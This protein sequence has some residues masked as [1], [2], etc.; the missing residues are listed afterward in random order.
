[1]GRVPGGPRIHHALLNFWKE[2]ILHHRD[3]FSSLFWVVCS[4][5]I[6][7]GSLWLPLGELHNPGPGFLPLLVGVLMAILS[8]ILLWQ[9]VRIHKVQEALH[10]LESRNLF[11]LI[12]TFLAMLIYV[13]VFSLLGFLLATI[14]LMIFLFKAIGEMGWKISL[15]GGT[16]ISLSIYVVFKVWLEV[17]FP[18]G[19]W[20]I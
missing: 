17:Q 1:M 16:L 15:V 5:L 20:G 3:F 11:K 14:P 12:A 4:L 19:V 8:T 18:I 2:G 9:S 13:P 10:V 6:I 7:L